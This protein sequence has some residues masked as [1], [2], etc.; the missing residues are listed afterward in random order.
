M[1]RSTYSRTASDRIAAVA[2]GDFGSVE[3]LESH[4][5]NLSRAQQRQIRN[6]KRA[7]RSVK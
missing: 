4:T 1:S 7:F 2:L 5:L 3:G 6:L